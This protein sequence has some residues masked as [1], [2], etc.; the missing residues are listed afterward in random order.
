MNDEKIRDDEAIRNAEEKA[1]LNY[2]RQCSDAEKIM[3]LLNVQ[4]AAEDEKRGETA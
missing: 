4:W 2:F 3:I 1:L